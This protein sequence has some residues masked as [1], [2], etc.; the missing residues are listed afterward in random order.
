MRSVWPLFLAWK[1][2]FPSQRKVSFFSLLAIIGVAL[3]VNVMI[4]VV[5][6]MQGFQQKFRTD[7]IDA[8][9]HAR[10]VPLHRQL[11]WKKS[12]GV[13]SS[14]SQVSK[15]TPY[16]QGHLL[17]QNRDYNSVPFSMGVEPTDDD[18]VLP[19]N[20]F[21][22][23]GHITVEGYGSKDLT[24]IP[25]TQVLE[26]DV[27]FITQQVANRLGVRPSTILQI[28][29]Q[30]KSD[31]VSINKGEVSVV[32][33]DPF[34]KS[35][36]WVI[37]FSDN[38]NYILRNGVGTV[39]RNASI[40]SG[41]PDLGWGYPKFAI[42]QGD[43]P[44][45]KGD[46]YKFQVFRSSIL[47]IYSPSMIEKAKSDEMAPPREVRVGGIF[48]VPWQGFHADALLGTR[49]F[50]ED[51]RGEVEICDGF[52]IKFKPEF[53]EDERRL[54]ELCA[55]LEGELEGDWSVIPWFVENAWFF[56]LL[57]F[58]EYLMVLIMIPI[59]LVAAFAIA[60]ALMTTVLRKIREI[61]LLV[62]MGGSRFEVGT[63]FCFQ[64]FII[65][66]LGALLG[67]AFALI[68]I[69]YR[70]SLMNF[71]VTK[72]AGEDGQAGVTQF[73]DFYSLDVPYPWESEQSLSTF[74]TFILFAILVSTVAGLL[75]AWRAARMNPAEALR[76]E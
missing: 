1:Q 5:A 10:A 22:E 34:V 4:V 27:V 17:V 14:Q 11:D 25:T 13:I 47:E 29:D 35:G 61:G 6:F 31:K 23:K 54:G 50:M 72:I 19:I 46:S 49:R 66:S 55:K 58:E 24:P 26:D 56:D 76:S 15:V 59:G 30:N 52:F 37:E 8:Q 12:V 42:Q 16:I 62:A 40:T 2:L 33:L 18:G 74:L 51:M 53:F 68:F 38:H 65:G 28:Y 67:C 32:R 43:R 44:F 20:E 3:G 70:D 39:E 36:E 57:K 63:I 64:G 75:P 9:G 21:L 71:I 41:S 73:Y 48:E 45:T 7:I 60:I 69:R